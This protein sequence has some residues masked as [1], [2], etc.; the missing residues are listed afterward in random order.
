MPEPASTPEPTPPGREDASGPSGARRLLS[1]LTG[2]PSR[3]QLIA[4]VLLAVLGYA[5]AVQIQLTRASD[6]FAGQPRDNLVE[7]LDSLSGASDRAQ[8]QITQLQHARDLLLSSSTG[9]AAA[10]A[11]AQKR[12]DDLEI[13]AGTI[14]AQG[15]GVIITIE[16]PESSVTAASLLNGI[17]ELRDAGAEAI[18]IN[19]TVRFVE[20][21]WIS[22][23]PGAVSV[24][25][26]LV[27]PPYVIDAIGSAHTL[28][29]AV[30]FPGGLAD[31]ISSL[32][33]HVTVQEQN[34]VKIDALHPADQPQYSH[35][36][37]Q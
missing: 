22:G 27:H 32:G 8:Q 31:E 11:D 26:H 18:Q 35:P 10:I 9:R 17:E 4:A 15:P 24:D 12:L 14:P 2:R 33:G 7:L 25:G 13:L 30:G 1:A 36:T 3:R 20:S 21:S 29:E 37:G 6:D 34:S 28:S 23:N 19:H 16:D 5:A